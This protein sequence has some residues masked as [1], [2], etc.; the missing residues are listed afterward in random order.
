[1]TEDMRGY[2]CVPWFKLETLIRSA[3]NLSEPKGLGF[4]HY[5]GGALEQETVDEIL[6]IGK[7]R[8]M[9]VRMDYI[10]GRCCKFDV[11]RANGSCWIKNKW[12]DH[13]DEDLIELLKS[14]D[15]LSAKEVI[16]TARKEEVEL[17][18][19]RLAKAMK[20]LSERGGKFTCQFAE[21]F[22]FDDDIYRGL[23]VGLEL[24]TIKNKYEKNGDDVWWIA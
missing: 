14:V 22:E 2:I 6:R 4:M 19:E 5:K 17:R 3:Y 15:I 1:M 7:D 12:F 23:H 16:A 11:I 20:F 21:K 10:N 13:T 8:R 24:G 18:Q 9:A